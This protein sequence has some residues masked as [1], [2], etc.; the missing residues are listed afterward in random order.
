L[1]RIAGKFRSAKSPIGIVIARGTDLFERRNIAGARMKA[2]DY[3]KYQG[4]RDWGP[5]KLRHLSSL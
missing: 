5:S 4:N 1:I 3:C 2:I